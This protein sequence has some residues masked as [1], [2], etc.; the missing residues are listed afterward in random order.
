VRQ[1]G[2]FTSGS[3]L[4][5][6]VLRDINCIIVTFPDPTEQEAIAIVLDATNE[7]IA[8]TESLIAKLK[9]I[10]QGLLH[11]LLTRGLDDNGELR[12]LQK[13]ADQFRNTEYGR[14]PVSWGSIPVG[15]LF[16]VQLGKMLSSAST[17]GRSPYPYL[18]NRNIQWDRV[19]LSSV[20]AMDFNEQER[21][22]FSL[23]YGD[24]LVC[25]GGEVGRTAIW[26][27]NMPNC[28]FQKA[29]HR[30]R[31]LSADVTPEF[32]LLFMRFATMNR[33]ILNYTSQTSIAHFTREK[34]CRMP[35][36]LPP[37]PEQKAIV[38]LMEGQNSLIRCE[39]DYLEKL[40]I[41]KRGLMQDLLTG[42]VRINNKLQ[43]AEEE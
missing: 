27:D 30:L 18:A 8:K 32:F 6:L 5:R 3:A 1:I 17:R 35:V 16:E 38:E 39:K 12:E 2:I 21:Q 22:K 28:F 37:P 15:E 43:K 42:R 20:E 33:W 36:F 41:L 29:I 13:N 26:H 31:P 4:R 11:D 40:K 14:L 19:D 9:A 34:F 10:K 7:A 24:L 25:E 23:R